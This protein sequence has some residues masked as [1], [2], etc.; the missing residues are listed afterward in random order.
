MASELSVAP[1]RP[2]IDMEQV[3]DIL[4]QV[5][6]TEVGKNIVAM[7][8]VYRIDVTSDQLLIEMTM[9]S[10]ACPM[11]EM[12]LDDVHVALQEALPQTMQ[13]DVRLVWEPPWN[14]SMMDK[15]TRQQTR[16]ILDH[17]KPSPCISPPLL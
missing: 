9:T 14:P 1:T 5:V 15:A 4:R 13:L 10:S 17:V 7:G 2:Q 16:I 11:G 6:D 12:I 8:L 3:R